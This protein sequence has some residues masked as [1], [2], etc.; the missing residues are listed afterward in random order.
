MGRI[1]GRVPERARIERLLAGAQEGRSGALVLR[2]DAG[3]GKSSLLDDAVASANGMTVLRVSGLQ[4]AANIPFTA[5]G[6]L[7][8]PHLGLLDGLPGPQA[9]ALRVALGRDRAQRAADRFAVYA[10]A[11]GLL[12]VLGERGPVL[13]AVDDAHWLDAGSAEALLF[14]ARRVDAEGVALLFTALT[15][16]DGTFP[17]E[18]LPSLTLAGLAPDEVARLLAPAEVSRQVLVRLVEGTGG[19]P[20][21]LTEIARSLTPGQLRGTEPLTDPLPAA[22][23]LAERLAMRLADLDA[24]TRRALLVAAAGESGTLEHVTAALAHLGLDTAALEEAERR[25][26]VVIEPSTIR[27]AHPLLRS[28]AYHGPS[29]ADRRAAHL[30]YAATAHPAD[31]DRRAWHAAQAAAGPDEAIAAE[32]E[33][34]AAG[35][36]ERAAYLAAAEAA[37]RAGTL[38]EDPAEAARRLEIAARSAVLGGDLDRAL[39]LTERLLEGDLPHPARGRILHLRGQALLSRG[40]IASA[41][42]AFTQAA[43]LLAPTDPAGGAVALTAAAHAMVLGDTAEHGVRFASR[44][45]ALAPPR[46][47]RVAASAR[48]MLLTC[49]LLTGDPAWREVMAAGDPTA[50]VPDED[51]SQAVDAN[52][53]LGEFQ[54]ALRALDR[55]LD[56]AAAVVPAGARVVALTDRAR[57]RIH[58]GDWNGALADAH[59]SARL[60]A[61]TGHRTVRVRAL[62]AIARISAARGDEDTCREAAS[63]AIRGGGALAMVVAPALASAALGLMELSRGDPEAALGQ[64]DATRRQLLSAG[65]RNPGV[66]PYQAD[67]VEA[68]VLTGDR[69]RAMR[70]A[71]LLLGQAARVGSGLAGLLTHRC[72]VKLVADDGLEGVFEEGWAR[73]GGLPYPFELA[74]TRLC[75][76]E[77]RLQQ[78][79]GMA[80]REPLEAAI[81]DFRR[82]GAAPWTARAEA[83]LAASGVRVAT[84]AAEH[85]LPLTHQELQ[86][87]LAV[88]EGLSNKEVAARLYLST[89]TVEFHLSNAYRKVGV[90]SRVELAR[91]VAE[92]GLGGRPSA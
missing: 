83:L 37:T 47:T 43:D 42:G 25:G 33:R 3:I 40:P 75:L 91:Y 69:H 5:L 1:V 4:P 62:A 80:A 52:L 86:V 92:G 38:S 16:E 61:L 21:A 9:A 41:A 12:G 22:V 84:P 68:L 13:V 57:V 39:A 46:D 50:D 85:G 17:A 72:R 44:A 60:A 10:G 63:E 18:G 2:G 32:L 82:L 55:V 65:V 48:T 24:P 71:S 35:M 49:R 11:L 64:L 29:D 28:A 90:R 15:G 56:P 31:A 19:N 54:R 77:R 36:A 87:T 20:L 73:F 27:F 79:R 58:L 78:R 23:T 53:W 34:V 8:R 70:E 89:K 81:A 88:A 67:L 26:L 51:L 6:E 30:A 14:A 7:L 45:V 74:R 59:E 76:G 66:V